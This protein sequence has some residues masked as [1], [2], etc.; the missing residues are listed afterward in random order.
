MRGL[1]GLHPMVVLAQ[2]EL[3]VAAPTVQ[4][5]HS[6]SLDSNIQLQSALHVV[7][8]VFYLPQ[9]PSASLLVSVEASQVQESW[10]L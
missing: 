2:L 6:G 9:S 7:V 8:A 10:T 3:V 4:G 5:S 1:Q